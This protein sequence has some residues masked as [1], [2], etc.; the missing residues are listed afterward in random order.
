MLVWTTRTCVLPLR[1]LFKAT[2]T[3]SSAETASLLQRLPFQWTAVLNVAGNKIRVCSAKSPLTVPAL[4]TEHVWQ[5]CCCYFY[6]SFQCFVL[7]SHVHFLSPIIALSRP[8]CKSHF[9]IPYRFRLSW[10]WTS[11]HTATFHLHKKEFEGL[12]PSHKDSFRAKKSP[13]ATAFHMILKTT[14]LIAIGPTFSLASKQA[15]HTMLSQANISRI[16]ST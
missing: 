14:R 4:K 1:R 16:W 8:N 10:T 5:T 2:E 12:D 11:T 6:S 3:E 13:C 9:G 7:C 15:F